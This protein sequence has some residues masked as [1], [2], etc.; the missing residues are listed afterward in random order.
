MTRPCLYCWITLMPALIALPVMAAPPQLQ[1]RLEGVST[2]ESVLYDPIAEVLYVSSMDGG[3]YDKDNKG[4]I[5]RVSLQ[6]RMLEREWVSGLHAPRG[7]GLHER[8]LYVADIDRL[9]EIDADTGN[10]IMKHEAADSI[11]L[12]DVAVSAAGEV[13]VSDSETNTI[14]LLREGR[15]FRWLVDAALDAP[16]GLLVEPER[17]LVGSWGTWMQPDAVSPH[18]GSLL[19]VPL[20]RGGRPIMLTEDLGNLD[21]VEP[22]GDGSWLVSDWVTGTVYH[23]HADGTHE[24]LLELVQGSADIAYIVAQRLLL[25]PLMKED[26]VVAYRLEALH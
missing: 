14:H 22:V 1:W 11:F 7:M 8:R 16:N 19:Y 13:Y 5:S 17:L 4:F 12:N 3:P 25:V 10:I 20:Q 9:I 24:P 21:G 6:G 26:A 18:V 15:L 2:P 23:V